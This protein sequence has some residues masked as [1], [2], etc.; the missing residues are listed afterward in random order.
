MNPAHVQLVET[1]Q[2]RFGPKAALT[3]PSDIAPWLTDWRGRWTGASDALMQP[4][5]TEEVAALV[6]LAAELGVPLVPQGGNT[7]M[8][9]GATPPADGSALIVS[10][11]RINR[12]REVDTGT[13]RCVA[14]AGVVLETL[15]ERVAT[16]GLRFP[17]TLGARGSATIGG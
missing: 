5:S 2:A 1:M 15:H 11:R 3:D 17:L 8:V 10:L 9:G 4:A 7:S 14:E 13:L 16:D 12:V 6:I